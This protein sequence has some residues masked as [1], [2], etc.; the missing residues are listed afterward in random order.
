MRKRLWGGDYFPVRIVS[1]IS[2]RTALFA[3]LWL[4]LMAALGVLVANGQVSIWIS[5]LG[6]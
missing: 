6:W 3:A 2:K 5:K 1:G 4:A